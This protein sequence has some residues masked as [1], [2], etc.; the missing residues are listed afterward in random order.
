MNL[1]N[2]LTLL[3]I[4]IVPIMIIVFYIPWLG[5][6]YLFHYT[7]DGNTHGLTWLYFIYAYD[8]KAKAELK[9]YVDSYITTDFPEKLS[10][11]YVKDLS[12]KLSKTQILQCKKAFFE[13]CRSKCEELNAPNFYALEF[14]KQCIQPI[15]KD[16]GWCITRPICEDFEL[17]E[18]W[19]DDNLMYDE[20]PYF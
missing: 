15:E 20:K 18:I 13:Y 14:V 17:G 16:R 19:L 2:K 9:I 10:E 4:L 6:H 7:V 1:P 11:I 3:R 5:S 12:G 8:L